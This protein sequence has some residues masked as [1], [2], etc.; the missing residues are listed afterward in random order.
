MKQFDCA[1]LVPGCVGSFRAAT[2]DEIIALGRVH[3]AIHHDLHGE[4]YTPE[5]EAAV[6]SLIRDVTPVAAA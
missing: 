4:D 3:A 2:A 1:D 5:I 6:R